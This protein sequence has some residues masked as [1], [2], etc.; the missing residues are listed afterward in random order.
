MGE[1]GEREMKW[2]EGRRGGGGGWRGVEKEGQKRSNVA[3]KKL[4]DVE[5]Y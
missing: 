3:N 5:D 2:K 1:E 4:A